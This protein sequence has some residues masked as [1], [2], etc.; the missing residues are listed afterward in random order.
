MQNW[1]FDDLL[2]AQSHNNKLAKGLKLIQSWVIIGSLAAYNN[3]EFVKLSW[4]K[5]IYLLE[6]KDTISGSEFFPEEMLPSIRINVSLLDDIYN[7]LVEYYNI[8]YEL[9]FVSIVKLV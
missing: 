8:A 3:H 2:S 1:K 6:I 5:Q 7:I 4:F 9:D